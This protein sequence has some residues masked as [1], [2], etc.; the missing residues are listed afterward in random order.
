MKNSINKIFILA[1]VALC[2]VTSCK[3]QAPVQTPRTITEDGKTYL[4]Q[5][6]ILISTGDG[7]RIHAIVVRNAEASEPSP[8][9][10]FHT[11]YARKSDLKRAKMAADHGYVGVVSY[12][13]GKGLSPD[14]IV[15]YKYE[16]TDTYELIDWISK[17]DW[18]NQKVGMYGGSYVGFTQWASVKHKVHSA[19]KTIVP[20]VSAAPGIAEPME[21]GV[22]FNFHFP[23]HHYVSNNK[24]LDTTLYYNGQ[25]WRDLNIKWFEKGVAYNVMDSLDGLPNP[26]FRERLLHP[27]YD[28]Y[29]QNMMPYQEEFAHINI[30]VLATT[31]YYDGGQIGTQYYLNEHTKY[32]KNAE[33]YLVIGPYTHFG[34]Q[35]KP[36]AHIFGYDIDPVAQ[37]DI[38]ELIFDWFDYVLKGEAKPDLLEDKINYQ[39]MGANA[40]GHAP[41]LQEMANDTLKYYLSNERSGV[42]FASL[43]DTGNNG[44]DIHYKLSE[45]P[46]DANEYLEQ[47]IDF[48]DRSNLTW[49]SSGWRN[50][51]ED[52]LLVG[53]G[54]SFAT[55]PFDADFELNGSFG[56]EISVSINKKDFD[57][58]VVLFEQTPDGKFFALT[59]PYVGRASYV[60]DWEHRQLLTPHEKVKLPFG[61]VRMTSRK[62]SKGSRLVVVVNGI[63]DP[64]S[65]INYG[66]GKNVSEETIK[67]A[68]EPLTIKWYGDSY[69]E[70]PVMKK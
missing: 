66:T 41:S 51:V 19:L 54:F 26:Q 45:Q 44:Q 14:S 62:I 10:L 24:Y 6:S 56:G 43:F 30:P 18:S 15:P 65:E 13:R 37:I 16:A 46:V 22:Y 64:F 61:I 47:T 39:V 33:H 53:H 69:L 42:G 32:N 4:V 29:W 8:A 36:N 20:S 58:K 5:D 59:L 35:E 50:I 27:T 48:T 38:T 34:A 67:D 68:K 52:S 28:A 2:F 12:T 21:N 7:A 1:V 25:R 3:E 11:I 60:R 23:W 17:Q 55:Q 49:N 31:G 70:I 9:V 57:Y 63:K 40:W